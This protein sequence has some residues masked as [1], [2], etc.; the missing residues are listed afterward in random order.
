MF[1]YYVRLFS[2]SALI[3]GDT[4]Q[5][6]QFADSQI[7][8][9]DRWRGHVHEGLHFAVRLTAVDLDS[10]MKKSLPTVLPLASMLAIG[11]STAIDNPQVLFGVDLDSANQDRWFG[12]VIYNVPS[13][14][15][16]RRS[17]NR[18][19]FAP[20]WGAFAQS[21]NREL[22]ASLVSA[23]YHL[24]K[25]Y[26]SPTLLDEFFELYSGLESVNSILQQKYHLPTK[27]SRPCVCG[28]P[29]QTPV[30]TG[31]KYAVTGL[32]GQPNDAWKGVRK[33]RVDLV[34]RH[35]ALPNAATG[36]YD[37]VLV[38]RQ[39]L[40]AAILDLMGLPI[41]ADSARHI[42]IQEPVAILI[43]AKL[44]G[45]P[46]ENILEVGPI[47]HFEIHHTEK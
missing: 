35:G 13:V 31:I 29:I 9:Y 4:A 21:S 40:R 24:R 32:A 41:T 25:S 2:R 39:A 33:T 28:A 23:M 5:T 20:I 11:H 8:V 42:P 34:H 12:Q 37:D 38:L 7:M 30:A 22:Q 27:E 6:F 46:P 45:V 14:W 47:P 15:L 1:N 36:L 26:N 43:S 19:T 18:D 10:A 3:I 44:K 17:F 16:H